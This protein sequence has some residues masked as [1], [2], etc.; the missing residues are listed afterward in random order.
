MKQLPR[1]GSWECSSGEL[2]IDSI[3]SHGDR[4][5]TRGETFIDSGRSL[6]TR[7]SESLHGF[8]QPRGIL[9]LLILFRFILRVQWLTESLHT[10]VTHPSP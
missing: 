7:S 6:S 3:I 9:G 8:H 2:A 1:R 4:L 10:K 5:A